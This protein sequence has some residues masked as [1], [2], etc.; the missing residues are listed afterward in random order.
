MGPATASSSDPTPEELNAA[1]K[2]LDAIG[3]ASPRRLS[4]TRS[5]WSERAAGPA[6]GVVALPVPPERGAGSG[7]SPAFVTPLDESFSCGCAPSSIESELPARGGPSAARAASEPLSLGLPTSDP[8][9]ESMGEL[10]YRRLTSASVGSWK[11]GT[12]HWPSL[13]GGAAFPGST[14][15]TSES[16]SSRVATCMVLTPQCANQAATTPA[17]DA[18]SDALPWREGRLLLDNLQLA[19][20]ADECVHGAVNLLLGVARGQLDA[21]AGLALGHDLGASAAAHEEC[22]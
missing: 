4:A 16:R 15:A 7:A 19:A 22:V 1:V 17:L 6:S 8:S 12:A 9:G 14:Q 20:H 11:A 21:D 3:R 5:T 18:G 10:L 13:D 2:A